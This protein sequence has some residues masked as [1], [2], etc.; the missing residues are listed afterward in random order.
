[1]PKE[2]PPRQM[3]HWMAVVY[4]WLD[5]VSPSAFFQHYP[6]PAMIRRSLAVALAFLTQVS[7]FQ[8]IFYTP[9]YKEYEIQTLASDW[10]IWNRNQ[11]YWEQKG[12]E[13]SEMWEILHVVSGV[14]EW[15][16]P[17]EGETKKPERRSFWIT[18]G[19]PE[20]PNRELLRVSYRRA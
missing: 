3:F 15:D 20:T 11:T 4:S 10:T 17:K 18:Q 8:M 14:L 2:S 6:K 16:P 19:P 1:M 7:A 12:Y 5:W 13:S 9:I